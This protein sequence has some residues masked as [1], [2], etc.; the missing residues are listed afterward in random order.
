[1][2][3]PPSATSATFTVHDSGLISNAL[4]VPVGRRAPPTTYTLTVVGG[5]GRAI[6]AAGTVV[7][8]SSTPQTGQQFQSWS[9]ATV[10]NANAS[11]TTLT[12]PAA[13]TM[14]TAGFTA[15]PTY[16]LTVVGGTGSGPYAAGTVVNIAATVPAGQQFQ[17]WSGA[18]VAS[19]VPLPLP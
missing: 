2:Y 14:V 10:A 19:P 13:N 18:T 1:M 16:T 3:N 9:G 7:N 15:S 12:M 17:S 4:V 8:I 5:N 6:Y 11:A